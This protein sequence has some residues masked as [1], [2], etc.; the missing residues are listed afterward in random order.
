MN[1]VASASSCKR[2]KRSGVKQGNVE[3]S[4]FIPLIVSPKLIAPTYKP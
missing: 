1:L 4:K 3:F 2:W